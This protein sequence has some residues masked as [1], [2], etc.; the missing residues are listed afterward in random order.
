MLKEKIKLLTTPTATA[1]AAKPN[2][3]FS[4]TKI[5]L[6]SPTICKEIKTQRKTAD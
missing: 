4:P 2:Q 3:S 1:P 5:Q 6:Q